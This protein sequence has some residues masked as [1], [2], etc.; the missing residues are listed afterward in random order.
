MI[1]SQKVADSVDEVA[2]GGRGSLIGLASIAVAD[3]NNTNIS[4]E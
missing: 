3:V 4:P 1:D 2:V